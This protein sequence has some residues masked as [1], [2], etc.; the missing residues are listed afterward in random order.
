MI[1]RAV[2][3]PPEVVVFTTLWPCGIVLL[4]RV[5]GLLEAGNAEVDLLVDAHVLGDVV[6]RRGFGED[7]VLVGQ[8]GRPLEEA[9]VGVEDVAGIRLAAG[10]AAE[11]E[12]QLAVGD[13]LLRQVVVDARASACPART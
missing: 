12:R 10:R 1:G 3:E 11:Q 5:I 9:R 6:G 4:E 2:S 13:G 7:H 8:L